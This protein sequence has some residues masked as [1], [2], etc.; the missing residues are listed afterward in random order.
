MRIL[1]Y[2]VP[3]ML[4]TI[5]LSEETRPV[6]ITCADRPLSELLAPELITILYS[7]RRRPALNV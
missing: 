6:K 5:N 4:H 1:P 2:I 3:T 7:V